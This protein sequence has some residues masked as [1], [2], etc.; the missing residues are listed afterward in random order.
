VKVSLRKFPYPYRAMLAI[1]NDIDESSS[2]YFLEIHN[3][4]NGELGLEIGDSFWLY[5]E[6]ERFSYFK[7]T[8]SEETE[9]AEIIRRFYNA[10]I[11]DC[12]HSFGNFS[13]KGGFHRDLAERAIRALEGA[14][15]KVDVWVN[16][17]SSLNTQNITSGFG[18]LPGT[19]E[20][21]TDISMPYGI[22]F[23]WD[24]ELTSFVGQERPF[25]L[26]EIYFTDEVRRTPFLL[27]K[28]LL[29]V[30]T[31]M[32]LYGKILLHENN[33]LSVPK[34]LRDGRI[35]YSFKRYGF[36][37]K[38]TIDDLPML[39]SS[40]TLEK[41]IKNEGFMILYIHLGKRKTKA[42][43]S[44]EVKASWKRLKDFYEEGKN[45]VTTT[46]RMLKYSLCLKHLEYTVSSSGKET[47][48]Y[49]MRSKDPLRFSPLS[50]GELQGITFYVNDPEKVKIFF[51]GMEIKNV[52][53]NQP[54]YRGK[55]SIGFPWDKNDF[56][57]ETMKKG[58]E[59][60]F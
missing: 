39:V 11:I 22:K 41:L 2:G 33:Q 58:G 3:Y 8:T 29:K 47:N 43:I 5:D 44:E 10:G 36:W 51:D 20:Y 26:S 40:N 7:G 13:F 34:K 52:V 21:H 35:I 1:C 23:I 19:K 24:G 48:I 56:V 15:I 53:K 16:H 27:I 18:D 30:I 12:L 54:D 32:I 9:A 4:L 6:D 28:N 17:G 59:N 45:L 46:S 49:I 14:G 31:K 37:D 42:P 57:G 50:P 25:K 60:G 55:P 38:A